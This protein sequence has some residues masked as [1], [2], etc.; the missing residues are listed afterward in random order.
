MG[1]GRAAGPSGDDGVTLKQARAERDRLRTMLRDGVDPLEARKQ[2]GEDQRR[3]AQEEAGK[4]TVRATAEAYIA[5]KQ[6]EWGA[7]SLA[8]W[9]RFAKRDIEVIAGLPIDSIGLAEVKRAV[10]PFV[11]AGLIA[12][13][14]SAQTRIQALL[15][16]ASEH[17]WRPEDRRTKFSQI[18]PKARKGEEPKRHPALMPER[19]AD[20]I[21]AAVARLR[22]TPSMSAMGLEF[23]ILNGVRISEGLGAEWSEID[24]IKA[25]WVIPGRRMKMGRE[26]VV[27]LS[28]RALDILRALEAARGNER[29]HVFPGARPGRPIARNTAYD[30]CALVTGG[31]AS[32]HGWRA[33]FRSWCSETGVDFEL[34]EA[35]LAHAKGAIVA[36]Y[37]R[38]DL[39]E[40][41][42]PIMERW[43]QF[44]S[45][46]DQTAEVIPLTRRA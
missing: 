21:R 31:K 9:R 23:T 3:K 29:R 16:F 34:S 27:P 7:S 46:E 42:R 40:R 26:H 18:A 13:A 15:D 25:L 32:P 1:L 28:E 17:G 24:L 20:A 4:K 38:S 35:A 6:R 5:Q 30:Q 37:Q 43:A 8:S 44:L 33:T 41:R 22:A 45:G 2:A 39:A 12:V 36:A 10:M 14:R 11:D 19:D